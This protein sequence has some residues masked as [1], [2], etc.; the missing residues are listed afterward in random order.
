M[1]ENEK[2]S[3]AV[4][5]QRG[6]ALLTVIIKDMSVVENYRNSVSEGQQI[7]ISFLPIDATSKDE[8]SASKIDSLDRNITSPGFIG[9]VIDLLKLRKEHEYLRYTVMWTLFTDVMVIIQ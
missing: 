9:Y 7:P 2:I 1:F 3:K 8:M 4:S 6:P 5:L